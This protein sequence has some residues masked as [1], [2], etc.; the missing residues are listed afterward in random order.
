MKP[1][2]NGDEVEGRTDAFAAKRA[3]FQGKRS[4]L[5]AKH[6]VENAEPEIVDAM[7]RK[8][9]SISAARKATILPRKA[10]G[11]CQE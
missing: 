2:P 9:L 11:D 8:V 3:G 1:R 7:D 6:V 10:A 4:Y 5:D